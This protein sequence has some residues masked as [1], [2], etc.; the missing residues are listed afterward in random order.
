MIKKACEL[1]EEIENTKGSNAKSAILSSVIGRDYERVTMLF[2]KIALDPLTFGV[3]KFDDQSVHSDTIPTVEN[4]RQLGNDLVNRRIT[5]NKAIDE[6][7]KTILVEDTIVRKWLI[8]IFEKNLR[9]GMTE[10]S[11]NKIFPKLIPTFEIG[12]CEVFNKDGKAKSLPDGE[13]IIDPKLDGLRCLCFIDNK[14]QCKFL[15]RG[16]KKLFNT[17]FIENEIKSSKLKNIILDGEIMAEDWNETI[18]IV[19]TENDHPNAKSLCLYVFDIIT[20]DEWLLKETPALKT[21]KSRECLLPE[22]SENVSVVPYMHVSNIE[23]ATRELE[24]Y[25]KRGFEGAV[26]KEWNS[27]YPFGRSRNWLKWKKMHTTEVKIEGMKLG[28]GKHE[29]R[30][31]N[32]ICDYGGISVDIGNGFT[33]DM[34]QDICNNFEKYKGRLIEVQYQDITVEGKLRFPVFLRFRVD[35]E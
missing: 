14:G 22:N 2:L 4:L 7:R 26:L 5:G 30:L 12:L 29:G 25:L 23:E 10:K 11:V 13:W 28:T 24:L 8:R 34:R 32:L 9:F 15:S 6:I 16:N 35:M 18:K 19:H 1:F 31:G 3:K 33:D 21:R 20:M 17:I 27:R